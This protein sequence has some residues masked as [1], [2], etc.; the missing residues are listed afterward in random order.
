MVA[1]VSCTA[2]SVWNKTDE[3]PAGDAYMWLLSL[4]HRRNPGPVLEDA[5]VLRQPQLNGGSHTGWLI[6]LCVQCSEQGIMPHFF[7]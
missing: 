2:V 7:L 5:P 3:M 4:G 1:Q 6:V